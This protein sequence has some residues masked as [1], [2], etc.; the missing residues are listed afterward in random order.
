MVGPLMDD[1][2]VLYLVGIA[3][4]VSKGDKG[5]SKSRRCGMLDAK[6]LFC[7][8]LGCC[9]DTSK[10]RKHIKHNPWVQ[11]PT[12]IEANYDILQMTKY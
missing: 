11:R 8:V 12:V 2:V 1:T 7:R 5:R 6:I 3:W 9:K 4:L 10:V